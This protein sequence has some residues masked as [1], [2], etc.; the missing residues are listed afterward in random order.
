MT[1]NDRCATINFTNNTGGYAAIEGGTSGANNSG[2]IL[3]KTD[4]AGS[5]S[6]RM[7]ITSSGNVGIGTTDPGV[8]FQ[9][10]GASTTPSNANV[11][12]LDLEVILIHLITKQYFQ[13]LED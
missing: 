12:V 10:V 13:K 1:G 11:V 6:E 3:F 5:S 8:K 2:Y 4:N 9:V 7:R